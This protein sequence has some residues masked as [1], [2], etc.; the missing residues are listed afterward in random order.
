MPPI[1]ISLKLSLIYC[2]IS[3]EFPLLFKLSVESKIYHSLF[4]SRN[5]VS[6]KWEDLSK[7]KSPRIDLWTPKSRIL[8][9]RF[10]SDRDLM[11]TKP[12]FGQLFCL[13]ILWTF[14]QSAIL[15]PEYSRNQINKIPLHGL[16]IWGGEMYKETENLTSKKAKC[17]EGNQTRICLTCD[18]FFIDPTLTIL[19]RLNFPQVAV[20]P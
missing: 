11:N 16:T 12:V 2:F 15:W 4:M 9:A 13:F 6:E 20:L 8:A 19:P 10:L 17:Y 7:I 3:H 18:M 1:I 14:F 5:S